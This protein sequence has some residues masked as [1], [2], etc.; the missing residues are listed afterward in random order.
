MPFQA[1]RLPH[2]EPFHFFA[3]TNKELHFHLFELTHTED[4][5][6]GNDLVTERFTDLG[7]TERNLHTAGLLYV[8][9]VNENTLCRFRT[10][11]YLGSA[12]GS[13][14]HFCGEHQVELANFRPV[15]CSG[16]RTCYFAVDNDLTEVFE[17]GIVQ[18][19]SETGMYLVAFSLVFQYAAVGCT[20]LCFIECFA[21]FFSGLVYFFLYFLVDLSQVIF[22]QYVGAIPF[23]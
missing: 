18:C 9:E 7:D 4:K 22:D 2:L 8:E 15:A 5:L 23:L 11:I 10:Q 19:F 12:I 6:T 17:V 13:R 16:D 20:E 1:G 3:R 14:T 21:E